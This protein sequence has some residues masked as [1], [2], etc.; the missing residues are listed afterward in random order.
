[1]GCVPSAPPTA[2][3]S[4]STEAVS[5]SRWV[6][7]RRRRQAARPSPQSAARARAAPR[8]AEPG[9]SPP[10][11]ASRPARQGVRRARVPLPLVDRRRRRCSAAA[12]R[13]A[14]RRS[15][16]PPRRAPPPP[17]RRSPS[18]RRSASRLASA[19]TASAWRA[20]SSLARTALSPREVDRL[21]ALRA[22][23]R[24]LRLRSLH[25][26]LKDA[27]LARAARRAVAV[28][29]R[30]EQPLL[31]RLRPRR[32]ALAFGPQRCHRRLLFPRHLEHLA[33]RLL[34]QRA[35]RRHRLPQPPAHLVALVAH[36]RQLDTE[37][38]RLRAR[39]LALAPP[40]P[41][42]ERP[43]GGGIPKGAHHLADRRP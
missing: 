19:A 38:R 43:L 32:R 6:G 17:Q 41:R 25:R 18:A 3:A 37:R 40:R 5:C 29:R 27:A 4:R 13:V 20:R 34:L 42:A 35:L 26:L 33:G 31:R 16:P 30:R 11:A 14:S 39:A 7:G 8:R 22:R 28:R 2:R 21:V 9:A 23:R 12:S 15:T 24:R 36:S 10:A 1:M